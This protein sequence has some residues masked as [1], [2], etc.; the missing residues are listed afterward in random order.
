M[1]HM[2]DFF[3]SM[4]RRNLKAT[5]IRRRRSTLLRCDQWCQ[6]HHGVTLTQATPEMIEGW[7]DSLRI[8]SVSRHH[9]RA[10]V[11]AFFA[12][13]TK[14]GH[15]DVDP[16]LLV[17]RPRLPRPLPH[18]I[19]T[20]DLIEADRKADPRMRAILRLAAYA[21]LRCH[22]IA[23]LDVLDCDFHNE[24]VM[25]RNG[26]GG[27]DRIVPM[28]PKVR[29]GLHTY[30]MP[31]AGWVFPNRYG[32]AYAP[33]SISAMAVRYLQHDLG[34]GWSLHDLRH[35]FATEVYRASGND[36]RSV[37][38]LLGHASVQTTQVYTQWDRAAARRAVMSLEPEPS[39]A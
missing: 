23:Q 1:P 32:H 38:E 31:R 36:V 18:P 17:E 15:V 34:T 27:K 4:R 14:H 29:E 2:L 13:A 37:Q 21:G 11:A 7:L 8:S 22:E 16:T 35:W 20:A 33:G 6:I 25:V 5:T 28:H 26:K 9:Y 19:T 10:D 3:A 39:P 30:G 24:H 12:W